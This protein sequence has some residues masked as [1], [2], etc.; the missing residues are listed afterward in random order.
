MRDKRQKFVDLAE[1]RV[2]RLLN[3]VRLIGNL[4]NRNNYQYGAEDVARIF[5]AIEAEI[6]IARK[7]FD[8]ATASDERQFKLR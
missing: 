7:R 8:V 6:R 3:E 5:A 2:T 1:S 4:S